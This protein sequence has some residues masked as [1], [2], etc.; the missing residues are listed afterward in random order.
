M[1]ETAIQ[2]TT[3]TTML[4]PNH[5][6]A[7]AESTIHFPAP[8]PGNPAGIE[9]GY[10][11]L[12]AMPLPRRLEQSTES[13]PG[14]AAPCSPPAEPLPE[15]AGKQLQRRKAGVVVDMPA[16]DTKAIEVDEIMP[17][18]FPGGL[19]AEDMAYRNEREAIVSAGVNACIAAGRAL[20]EIKTYR[21][22]LLWKVDFD[23][24]EQYCSARWGYRKSQ[25]YRL[26]EAGEFISDLESEFSP[27]GENLPL[28]EG[29]LRPL[30][31]G[32]PKEHRVEC[33]QKIV[34]VTPPAKLTSTI[35]GA[36]VRKFLNESG[37]PIKARKQ[38][39]TKMQPVKAMDFGVTLR[40]VERFLTLAMLP[41]PDDFDTVPQEITLNISPR[42]PGATGREVRVITITAKIRQPDAVAV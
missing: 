37:L 6:D 5:L 22:G 1:T 31:T 36:G 4:D 17:P 32:V 26:V 8:G 35:V 40:A 21:G 13:E 34:A 20:Y 16:K 42:D 14:S 29:Q 25:G 39:K 10:Q 41:C 24:F 28:N 11:G 12:V 33:W 23:S 3:T 2:F 19:G 18:A 9:P 27:R 15:S 30:I 7:T 38:T